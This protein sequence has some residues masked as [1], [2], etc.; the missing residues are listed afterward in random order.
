[1]HMQMMRHN[2]QALGTRSTIIQDKMDIDM[3]RSDTNEKDALAKKI[4]GIFFI[5]ERNDA[6]SY[7]DNESH[8][9]V[10]KISYKMINFA[11]DDPLNPQ[12]SRSIQ[13]F[14]R[15]I[16]EGRDGMDGVDTFEGFED[17]LDVFE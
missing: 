9:E 10:S 7:P 5:V 8:V 16:D 3:R 6:E 12:L 1:M 13:R 14:R 2:V 17:E 11:A 4:H 15:D